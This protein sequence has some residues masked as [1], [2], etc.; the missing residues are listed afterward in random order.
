MMAENDIWLSLQPFV[1]EFTTPMPTEAARAK[2]QQVYAGTDNAYRLANK[3]GIETAW[4]T[5]TLFSAQLAATQGAQ[6]A[7]MKRWYASAQV[8]EMVTATN[9]E[10]LALSGPRNPYPGKLGVVAQEAFAD[11]L[12]VDGNPLENLDLVANP[13]DNFVVIMKDGIVY[14]NLLR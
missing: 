11:L 3:Y 6:V 9:A 14:K 7:Y 8:L 10:L 4:G 12:L 1:H 2:Q 5:D 13:E